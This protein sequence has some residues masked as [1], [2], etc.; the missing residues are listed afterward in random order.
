V[1]TAA[2]NSPAEKT[3]FDESAR[4]ASRASIRFPQQQQLVRLLP[5]QV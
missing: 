1:A 3:L 2:S 4:S 5:A